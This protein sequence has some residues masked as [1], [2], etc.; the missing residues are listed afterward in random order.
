MGWIDKLQ[1]NIVC[2]DTAPIIYFM[3]QNAQFHSKLRPFFVELDAGKFQAVTSVLTLVEVLVHP[4]RRGDEATAMK[5]HDILLSAPNVT[6]YAVTYPIAQRA[7]EL[8]AQHRLKTPDAIQLAIALNYG[9]TAFFTNDRR[10]PSIP[11]LE[12]VR[13]SELE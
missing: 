8:R 11:G 13:L 7:A 6:T 12:I 5:Y 3:E 4:L 1:G 9:A 2:L 10:I